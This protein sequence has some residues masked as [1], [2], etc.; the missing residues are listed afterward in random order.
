MSSQI[1]LHNAMLFNGYSAM[2]SCAVLIKDGKIVDVFNE[3]RFKQKNFAP[4]VRFIDLEG[5]CLAPGFI[6]THIHGIEGFGTDD[7]SEESILKMSEVLPKYGVTSFIP[8]L[9]SAPKDKLFKGMLSIMKAMGHEKGA[10]ILGMHLEGPFISPERLGVQTPSS[11]SPVDLDYM[12]EIVSLAQGS[13]VNMTVAPELK[14]M[15]EL[16]L[17]CL[18]YG[19]ILQAGHTNATYRQMVEGMQ[20]R[21]MHVTHLFNAM[22]RIH[23]RDPGVVGAVFIHPELSCEIIADGFHINPEIIKFLLRCK[24]IDKVVL[25]TDA[26][27]PTKQKAER[28]YANGDE[29]YLDK[30]FMRKADN[31]IAGSALT[32]IDGVKNLV[33]FGLSPEQAVQTASYNPAS[34]MK[35]EHIG[36]ISPGYDADMVVFDKD[37]N[38]LKTIIKGNIFEKGICQ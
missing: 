35:Q 16:A 5:A 36:L 22:S 3:S 15:R 7:L 28:L 17:L 11:I 30:C 32:M 20:A 29:V 24:P 27:K 10:K 12:R 8:T 2:N 26:L 19:I 18:E 6:D 25:V 1:C 31:V 14:G 13:I 37:F 33:S 23:H 38:V 21:I 9:Y 34:I 4:D